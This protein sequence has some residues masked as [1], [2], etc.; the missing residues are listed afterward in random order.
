MMRIWTSAIALNLPAAATMRV[1]GA[2]GLHIASRAGRLWLTESGC[3]E[4]IFLAPG[5]AERGA[6]RGAGW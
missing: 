4:D 6:Y 2:R 1:A 3:D 5:Q